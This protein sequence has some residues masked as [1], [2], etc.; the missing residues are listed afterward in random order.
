MSPVARGANRVATATTT[1]ARG[2][3][4]LETRLAAPL[5]R[6]NGTGASCERLE[7]RK[8]YKLYIGGEFPRTESGR[9]YEVFDA[10]G[11]LLANACRGTR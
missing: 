7:I 4:I 6:R 10:R 1:R 2:G 11:R 8:T 3:S 9:A 5:A